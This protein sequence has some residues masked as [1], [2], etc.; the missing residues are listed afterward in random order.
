MLVKKKVYTPV[1][2][3]ILIRS[4]NLHIKRESVFLLIIEKETS[5]FIVGGY[6]ILSVFY[7]DSIFL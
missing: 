2:S 1:F 5:A 6:I 7:I 3:L 4:V